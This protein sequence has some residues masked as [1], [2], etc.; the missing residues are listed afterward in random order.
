MSS[1]VIFSILK[2]SSLDRN[3]D[4][5]LYLQLADC[6]SNAIQKG[7]L[8]VAEKLPGTRIM[9]E[10]LG[11][12]RKT[13][14]AAY[15]ELQAQGW[16]E[17][18]GSVGSFILPMG[19][20]VSS[21]SMQKVSSDLKWIKSGFSFKRSSLLDSPFE[22]HSCTLALNDGQPDYRL[23]NMDELT[24][25]YRN[26]LK[27]KMVARKLR[28]SQVKG[29]DYFK[30]QLTSYLKT[31]RGISVHSNE[32][33]LSKSTEMILFIVAQL[34]VDK[35]SVVLVGNPSYF[36]ANMIFQQAGARLKT[37]PVDED[38]LKVEEIPKLFKRGE[39]RLLYL[40]PRVDYPTTV[41]LSMERRMRLLE[42]AHE[43]DFIIVEDDSEYEFSYEKQME[44]PLLAHDQFGKVLYVGALGR[45][46]SPTFKTGFLISNAD[47]IE[48]GEKLSGILDR[49][50]DVI[51]EQ[52]LGELIESGE[53]HRQWKKSIKIYRDRR[54]RM[55]HL[56]HDAFGP[57]ITFSIPKGGLAL[58]VR[59]KNVFSL[60]ELVRYCEAKSLFIPRHCLFQNKELT[61]IRIGFGHLELKEME[62]VV[63][64]LVEG[65]TQQLNKSLRI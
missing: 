41:P 65:V 22:S 21:H 29:S 20:R 51:M 4:K 58:W 10:Y 39:I 6:V 50:E 19:Q 52:T 40:N 11:I 14:V 37:I 35:G 48:E 17:M 32:L 25:L 49:Q 12:H 26:S 30:K 3:A 31:V 24:R 28:D 43:L 63:K 13:V 2:P 36:S 60:S 59:F 34:L 55:V 56:L 27:R 42:I 8:E 46:L 54:N 64:T 61:A 5:P 16:I 38:G 33:L 62:E 45:S 1:P 47:L 53:I 7:Q 9:A 18:K 15:E 57:E 44:L 23:T